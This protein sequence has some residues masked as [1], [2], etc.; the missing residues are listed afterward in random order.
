[1]P[2]LTDDIAA[3]FAMTPLHRRLG[4]A[5][6]K[7]EGGVLFSGEVDPEFARADGMPF[8]HGGAVGTL[9]DSAATFA[10][11]A[12]TGKV[13][14]TVDL[15]VDYLRPVPLGAVEVRGTVVRAGSA[16][17][18]AGAELRDAEGNL[19]ATAVATFAAERS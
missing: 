6:S 12:E 13:W 15:R 17:G 16:I 5:V 4:V 8:L 10:L 3:L 1:M 2:A 9:L 11:V 7:V 18:R 19:C 14:A